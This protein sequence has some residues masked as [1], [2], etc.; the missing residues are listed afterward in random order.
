MQRRGWRRG[1]GE[2]PAALNRSY[3]GPR[4]MT[5]QIVWYPVQPA[6]GVVQDANENTLDKVIA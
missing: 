6:R 1:G 3:E 5:Y 2:G 4:I